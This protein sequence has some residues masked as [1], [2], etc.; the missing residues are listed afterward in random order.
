M[1][2]PAVTALVKA[3]PLIM[4]SVKRKLPKKD[5][6]NSSHLVCLVRVVSCAGGLSQPSM[7]TAPMPKRSQA[8]SMTGKMA[9]RG[10]DKAT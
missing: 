3:T 8:S 9:A 5:S 10:L 1:V 2:T 6:K 4:Q 7:A